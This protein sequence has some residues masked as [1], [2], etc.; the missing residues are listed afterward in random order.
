M[1]DEHMSKK[2]FEHCK[3]RIEESLSAIQHALSI[4]VFLASVTSLIDDEE[5][6]LCEQEHSRFFC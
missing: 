3:D 1:D 6:V 4:P 5:M 2:L